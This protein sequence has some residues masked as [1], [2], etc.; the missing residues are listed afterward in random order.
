MPGS[1]GAKGRC[2]RVERDSIA[3]RDAGAAFGKTPDSVSKSALTP[4]LSPCS[5]LKER[6]P[7]H[8]CAGGQVVQ[9][10]GTVGTN[11]HQGEALHMKKTLAVALAAGFMLLAPASQDAFAQNVHVQGTPAEAMSAFNRGEYVKARTLAAPLAEAG[12]PYAMLI[13]G[14]LADNGAGQPQDPDEASRWYRKAADA[15]SAEGMLRMAYCCRT[16]SGMP[17]DESAW[18]YWTEKAAQAGNAEA[19]L[20]LANQLMR[21]DIVKKDPGNAFQWGLQAANQGY[22]P[23]MIFVGSCYAAGAGTDRDDTL[24]AQ[25]YARAEKLGLKPDHNVFVPAKE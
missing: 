17:K 8:R 23:A 6:L 14:R 19:Q 12:N 4:P 16:G 15:G 25:W 9:S 5:L 7:A 18:L 11:R 3:W 2:G 1:T 10:A 24:A 21:G 22:G 13:M 20:N